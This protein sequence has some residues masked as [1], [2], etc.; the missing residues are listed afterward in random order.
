MVHI[1]KKSLNSKKERN[2]DDQGGMVQGGVS[3]FLL[4]AE[5]PWDGL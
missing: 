2:A 3:G 1:F 5:L 4:Y